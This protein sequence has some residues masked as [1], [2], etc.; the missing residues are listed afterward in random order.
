[1]HL[2]RKSLV[3]LGASVLVVLALN[4]RQSW[5]YKPAPDDGH[6]ISELVVGLPHTYMDDAVTRD[7]DRPRV[8]SDHW[9]N[10]DTG[11]GAHGN[12]GRIRNR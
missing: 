6:R 5:S 8:K 11:K 2:S 10:N 7:E 4:V 12:V 3:V 9:G 1:M